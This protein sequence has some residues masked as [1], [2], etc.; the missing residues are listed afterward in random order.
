[1]SEELKKK[2]DQ[3]PVKDGRGNWLAIGAEVIWTNHK[4]LNQLIGTVVGFDPGGVVVSIDPKDKDKGQT[5][6]RV[7]FQF[8]LTLNFDPRIPILMEMFRTVNPESEMILSKILE[9]ELEKKH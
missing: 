6:P 2:G 3:I 8:K 1:M 4:A 9:S 5:P 7:H